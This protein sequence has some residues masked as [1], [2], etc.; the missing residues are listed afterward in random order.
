LFGP[1]PLQI[2]CKRVLTGFEQFQ[3][4]LIPKQ[5]FL[6]DLG[7]SWLVDNQYNMAV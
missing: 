5:D 7:W 2:S 1:I 6:V 3:N 4:Y